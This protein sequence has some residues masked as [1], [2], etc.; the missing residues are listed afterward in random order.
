M[1]W[2]PEYIIESTKSIKRS[3]FC[4]F[5]GTITSQ[6]TLSG[7]ANSLV[8]DMVKKIVPELVARR[9]TLRESVRLMI[10]AIPSRRYGEIIEY[11]MAV[12]IRPGFESL[13]DFLGSQGVPFIIISGGLRGM[14]EARLGPLA[15][16]VHSIYALDVDR[17]GEHIKIIAPFEGD[18]ELMDK[19]RIIAR[20]P[21]DEIVSIGDG[22][23]DIKMA[24]ESNIVFARDVLAKSLEKKGIPYVP[25][26][27]FFD[28]QR[29][30]A[31]R[32]S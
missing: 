27:D 23:T 6:E 1:T 5:D 10:E 2:K 4:D 18:T 17:T 13:L 20:Y 14:V 3:V 7:M 9:M 11:V 30:L 28:I 26:N 31:Q 8:P 29:D 19:T 22:Y 25:W 21:A 16:M 24:M 32:W 15:K 12:P